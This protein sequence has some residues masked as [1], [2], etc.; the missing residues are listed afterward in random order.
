MPSGVD[1]RGRIPRRVRAPRLSLPQ[2]PWLHL[3]F[4]TST[5]WEE[6]GVEDE[7]EAVEAAMLS[8]PR[9]TTVKTASCRERTMTP[10]SPA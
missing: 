7:D 5:P 10:V 4:R 3:R 9:D 1:L 2:L 6:E 8:L